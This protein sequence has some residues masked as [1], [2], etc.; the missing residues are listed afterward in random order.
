MPPQ[1]AIH[2]QGV[3]TGIELLTWNLRQPT[4]WHYLGWTFHLTPLLA[5][6]FWA[7]GGREHRLLWAWLSA[8]VPLWAL[9]HAPFS[10]WAETRLF[11][12][13]LALCIT[14]AAL[15]AL[16]PKTEN[17]VQGGLPGEEDCDS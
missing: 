11:L 5:L 16:W 10:V 6:F 17:S 7:R 14:P 15:F 8:L 13:P 4:T 12:V 9:I 2:P 3:K 1:N